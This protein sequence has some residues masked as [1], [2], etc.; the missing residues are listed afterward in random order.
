MGRQPSRVFALGVAAVTIAVTGLAVAAGRSEPPVPAPTPV[1]SPPGPEEEPFHALWPERTRA[2]AEAAQAAADEAR[3]PEWRLA[4]KL[5]AEM[6]VR[7]L[8]GWKNLETVRSGCILDCVP[9]GDRQGFAVLHGCQACEGLNVRV[10]R[11]VTRGSGGI[12]SVTAV[13]SEFQLGVDVGDVVAVGDE[14]FASS[15]A[16]SAFAPLEDGT[17]IHS[18]FFISGRCNIRNTG[19]G[20]VEG[21]RAEVFVDAFLVN[22]CAENRALGG[23]LVAMRSD[24]TDEP[25][26][27]PLQPPLAGGQLRL[28][29]FAAVP[30][31]FRATPITVA[32]PSDPAEAAA[33][34]REFMQARVRG[35]DVDAMLSESALRTYAA[36]PNALSL[37]PSKG[38]RHRFRMRDVVV[39]TEPSGYSVIV[40]LF[41]HHEDERIPVRSV[42]QLFLEAGFNS[43][44]EQLP[45]VIRNGG[46]YFGGYTKNAC[47][48]GGICWGVYLALGPHD[49]VNVKAQA[50]RLRQLGFESYPG[51]YGV[52]GP[53]SERYPGSMFWAVA[54]GGIG[55]DAGAIEALDVGQ[56]TDA[57]VV[58]FTSE[59]SAR[60]FSLQL[61][62]P[63]VAIVRIVIFG[64]D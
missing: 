43:Q 4:A 61:D 45:L 8:M 47:L 58:Y 1:A 19:P 26:P 32:E 18:G 46:S 23:Y 17:P 28:T 22:E 36:P 25:V 9:H 40:V 62:P 29:A 51:A 52:A 16:E 24:L 3:A 42:E 37:A 55:A 34:A 10:E 63:P 33:F 39:V 30:V 44:G 60:A 57:A 49:D 41:R 6:F 21:G 14:V 48:H 5:T 35:S 31:V 27:D 11:L 38:V 13:A 56:D 64:A 54:A 15:R 59:E 50:D 7:R 2:K 20:L 12:W 53:G